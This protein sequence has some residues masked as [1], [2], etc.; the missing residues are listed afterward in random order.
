[1]DLPEIIETN[2]AYCKESGAVPPT[3]QFPLSFHW[4]YPESHF[5]QKIWQMRELLPGYLLDFLGKRS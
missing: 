1:M 5:N 4:L 2:E 3:P